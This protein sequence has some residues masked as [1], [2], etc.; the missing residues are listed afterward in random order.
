MANNDELA[1]RE[2][3]K[4]VG[5]ITDNWERVTKAAGNASREVKEIRSMSLQLNEALK[6][7]VSLQARIGKE[8]I[9]IGSIESQ[10]LK[11]KSNIAEIDARIQVSAATA[12]VQ[13]QQAAVIMQKHLGN[14][15][16]LSKQIADSAVQIT[17]G[18]KQGAD[19]SQ[20]QNDLSIKQNELLKS[21]TLL[22]WKMQKDGKAANLAMLNY[23]RD[24]AE[25][26]SKTLESQIATQTE[27]NKGI[28]TSKAKF[29]SLA[30]IM[31][32]VARIPIIGKLINSEKVLDSMESKFTATGSKLKSLGAG[33]SSTFSELGK[34]MSN[35]LTIAMEMGFV[36]AK[37]IEGVLQFDKNITQTAN[38][39]GISKD[40]TQGLYK[41]FENITLN[42]KNYT[43]N[44]DNAFLSI[45]NQGKALNELQSSLGTNVLLTDKTIQNQILLTK[46][47]GMAEDEAAAIQQYALTNNKTAE[48]TLQT[49]VKQNTSV[50]SYRKII[51]E[52]AKIGGQLL[53][54]YKNSPELL[55]QATVQAN[56]L[57]ITVEQAKKSSEFLLDFENS[58]SAELEAELLTGKS[59][60]LEKARSLALDGKS[61]EAAAEM[62]KQVG[63]FNDYSKLNVIQQNSLAKAIGIS[64]DELSNALREQQ[65]L[66]S[67]GY[68]NKEA[69]QNQYDII[70]K[71]NDLVGLTRLQEEIRAKANGDVLLSQ[72]SQV[73]LQ[74]R[75]QE[76]IEKIKDAF[77]SIASGPLVKIMGGMANLL[78]HAETLKGLLIASGAAMSFMATRSIAIAAASAFTSSA[79][80]PIIGAVLGGLAAAATAASLYSMM[81]SGDSKVQSVNDGVVDP[82]GRIT[83]STP[84]GM[85]VPNRKDHLLFTTNPNALLNKG[86]DNSVMISKLDR[87]IALLSRGGNVYID[88]EKCG[89]ALA[90][91]SYN[92]A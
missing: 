46:Q 73:S 51:S 67:L 50:I 31:K 37:L 4:T 24:T 44:L 85:I 17:Q 55:T 52:V 87:M 58:I 79:Q 32:G 74:Q 59:I 68:Q 3:I 65:T 66:T 92:Y 27:Y 35:P 89:T 36:F 1:L 22:R 62:L 8:Y 83:V 38:N 13:Q 78:S 34:I 91:G 33:I 5:D 90:K 60:N 19:V 2:T 70:K 47:M 6:D 40:L 21:E 28:D 23:Q 42:S 20:L 86:D 49:I 71:N 72:I 69:L 77:V 43:N 9:K 64:S 82:T 25:N 29:G 81:N 7:T 88:S 39:L 76:S 16:S 61:S 14:I 56:K 11:V 12:T 41:D 57:G 45:T 10:L 30:G 18:L 54:Q 75:F 80:V 63:S 53:A 48:Q 26:L 15:N 84:E